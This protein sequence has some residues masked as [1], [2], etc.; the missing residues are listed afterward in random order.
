M[1]SGSIPQTTMKSESRQRVCEKTHHMSEFECVRTL[2]PYMCVV[3]PGPSVRGR[4][5][6]TPFKRQFVYPRQ[7]VSRAAESFSV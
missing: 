3:L 6:R 5:S 1:L 7:A 2:K 4:Q